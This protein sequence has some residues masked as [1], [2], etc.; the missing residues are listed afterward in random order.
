MTLAD[1]LKV[2]SLHINVKIVDRA[3]KEIIHTLPYSP[4]GMED[5]EIEFVDLEEED[6]ITYVV[7]YL[8]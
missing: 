3:N 1:F 8:L 6:G 7:V 2:W 4:N 5:R